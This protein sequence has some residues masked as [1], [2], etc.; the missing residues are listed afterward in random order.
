MSFARLVLAVLTLAVSGCSSVSYYAQSIRG[1]MGVIAA[2]RPT[3]DVI[4]D[5]VT[6]ASLRQR[7]AEVG[8]LR[9]FA[10][11]ELGLPDSGS[12]RHYADVQREAMVWSLVAA[13]ADDLTPREWCFP[14]VGCT[15]YR[16]YFDREAARA[17]ADA[18]QAEG[19]DTTVEPVP[20]YS[21]L[22]WF[23]D[24]LPSTVIHWPLPD[25]AGLIFHELA[26][27]TVYADDDSGF[28]EAYA[29]V[30][31][32]E[33]VRRWLT[34]R[35][36]PVALA[37]YAVQ[38]QRRLQFLGLLADTR[39]QLTELYASR[40]TKDELTARKQAIFVELRTAYAQL[41]QRWQGY[42]GY[43][44]WFSRPL[45]NARLA[46]VNTYYRLEP[47]FRRLLAL[48]GNDMTRFHAAT[49]QLAAE[50]E[51]QRSRCIGSLLVPLDAGRAPDCAAGILAAANGR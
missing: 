30:V 28:N 11:D 31:E 9:Q 16:G 36:D 13:P 8:P 41:K 25:I 6:D 7:L 1:Q 23:D 33:G 27:E 5:P 46:S 34:A 18:L 3:V 43:D 39:Q 14:V 12:F 24:P 49:R 26:H 40:P 29:T 44:R 32:K 42:T 37:E 22:G 38:E 47:A 50:D 20:A 17:H 35:N 51:A 45:N 4:A 2:S 15:A 48:A 19:W 21:T 10:V